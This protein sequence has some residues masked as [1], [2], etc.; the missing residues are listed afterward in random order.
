MIDTLQVSD[1]ANHNYLTKETEL[2]MD[3]AYVCI[4]KKEINGVPADNAQKLSLSVVKVAVYGAIC[5]AITAIE[6]L[7]IRGAIV[8]S[9]KAFD[10]NA[11]IG[12][13]GYA[14]F[15]GL[16]IGAALAGFIFLFHLKKDTKITK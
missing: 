15:W 4:D 12:G 1:R 9:V 6:S 14:F 7:L 16:I 3:T 5:M 10:K 11:D 2:P 13:G 8:Y